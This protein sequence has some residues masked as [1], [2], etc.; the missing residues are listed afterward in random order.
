M[1]LEATGAGGQEQLAENAPRVSI[2][3]KGTNLRNADGKP[4][5]LENTGA[6]GQKEFEEH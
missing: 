2:G 4:M 5:V 1:M 3:T 6:G